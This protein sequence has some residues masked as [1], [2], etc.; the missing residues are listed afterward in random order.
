MNNPPN[1]QYEQNLL[2]HFSS[3]DLHTEH[4]TNQHFYMFGNNTL[5]SPDQK[6]KRTHF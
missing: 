5:M 1:H 3:S 2:N 6:S 4:L